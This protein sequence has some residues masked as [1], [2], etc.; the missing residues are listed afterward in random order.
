MRK[1]LSIERGDNVLFDEYRYFFYIYIYITN[2]HKLTADQ[3]IAEAHKRCNQENL[4]GNLKSGVR[5]L[6][7]PVNTLNANWAYMTMMSLAWTLKAWCAL[8][9]PVSEPQHEQQQRRLLTMEFRTFQ[10]ALID[11]PCQI[12]KTARYIR[13]RIQAWNPWLG[14]FFRLLDALTYFPS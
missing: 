14:T 7:A 9:L 1:N 2:D 3:V 4:I 13:W 8:M 6:H 5:A 11:I 12:V 10:A